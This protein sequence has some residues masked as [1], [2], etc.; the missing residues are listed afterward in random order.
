MIFLV[1]L[2][3]KL[4]ETVTTLEHGI[5]GAQTCF[6][7]LYSVTSVHLKCTLAPFEV[8]NVCGFAFGAHLESQLCRDIGRRIKS[9]I[10][11]SATY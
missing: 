8:R 6:P 10:S 9:S 1:L 4:H 7:G 3:L 2:L 11:S 5:S